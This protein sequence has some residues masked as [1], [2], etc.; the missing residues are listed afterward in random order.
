MEAAVAH[1]GAELVSLPVA[2]KNP[3]TVAANARALRR[4]IEAEHV[5]LVHARSRAPAFS[6]LW[7][8]RA[9]RIPF[10]ATYAGIYTARSPWKRW[11]NGVMARADLVIANSEYTR[12]HVL[13]E[14]RTDPARVIAIP[15][16]IDLSVFS[17]GAVYVDRVE[18]LRRAWRIPETETRPVILLAGRLTRWKGQKLMIEAAALLKARG[19][20]DFILVLAGDDQGRE[21]YRVELEG[22]VDRRG[23][24]DTVRLVGHCTDM[25]AAYLAADFAVAPSLRPEA[26]GRTAVEP[27]AMGRPVLAAAHGAVEETVLPGE[28]GWLVPPGD[29][30][31]WADAIED[32][33][34]AGPY[35][36]AR[37][38]WEGIAQVRS[39][40]SVD[41]MTAAT[42]QTYAMLLSSSA[43]APR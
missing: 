37:M 21:G 24:R 9:A 25:P 33:L 6:C 31:A 12:A 1:A 15:R 35:A 43:F 30:D 23:L 18:G 28:T 10:V 7:A 39:R 22:A 14:H 27:Q 2:S 13:T 20:A 26:F 17:P 32:A 40:F 38:G 42:L 19:V 36:W 41:A 5:S 34:A 4:L 8:A 11:Y 3:L 29:V 16:G